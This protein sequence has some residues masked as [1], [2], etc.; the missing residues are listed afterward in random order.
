MNYRTLEIPERMQDLTLW[1]G[2]AVP[3]TTLVTDDGKIHFKSVDSEKA[4]ECKRDGKCSMCGKPLDYWIAFMVTAD[5]A[6]SRIVYENPN[7]EEC[8]RYAFNVC[9][10]LFYS[11]AKY[12]R[13]ED[14]NIEGWT[15]VDAHPEREN[16]QERP[17]KLGIYICNNYKNIIHKKIYRVVKVSSPKRLE[18]ID[19]K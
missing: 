8:L 17:K 14:L 5:E 4:W 18:W 6:E 1:H 7:H 12:T 9:P 3:Y 2:V 16:G 13:G 15:V 10:W 19:G 11:K